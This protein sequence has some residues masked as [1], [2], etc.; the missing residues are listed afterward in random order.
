[1]TVNFEASHRGP[2]E[3]NRH[4]QLL[5]KYAQFMMGLYLHSLGYMGGGLG[6]WVYYCHYFDIYGPRSSYLQLKFK[7]L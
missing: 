7:Y 1:M 5:F 2:W 3:V 6:G 4:F